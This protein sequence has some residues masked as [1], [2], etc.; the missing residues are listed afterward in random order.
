MLKPGPVSLS[1][2][3]AHQSRCRTLSYFSSIVEKKSCVFYACI[4]CR[5]KNKTKQKNKKQNPW[6]IGKVRIEGGTSRR[7]KEFWDRVRHGRFTQ[8]DV[9]SLTHGT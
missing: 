3:A 6:P 7:Q 8:E 2:P 5:P 1:L 9:M 4:T